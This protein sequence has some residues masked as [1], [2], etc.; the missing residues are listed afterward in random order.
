M[1]W[2]LGRSRRHALLAMIASAA[3][4]DGCSITR[5]PR[6]E[7]AL[8][9]RRSALVE[10]LLQGRERLSRKVVARIAQEQDR[11]AAAGRPE[12]VFDFLILSGGGDYGAFGAG[13]LKGWGTVTDPAMTR[14]TFDV[15]SGVSTGALIAPLAFV[16]TEETYE[17]AFQVYQNPKP[18]WSAIRGL[19]TSLLTKASFAKSDWLR[20]EIERTIDDPVIRGIE[21]GHEN[22]RVLLIGTT[23]ADLG[24]LV[25]WDAAQIAHQMTVEGRPRK[26]LDDVILA[27]ASIPGVFPPV[28][29]DGDLYVDGGVTRNIA[30]TTDQQSPI[31]AL[32][33]WKREHPNRKFPKIRMWIIIN[34]QLATSM[35][36]VDPGWPAQIGRAL[37]ISIRS[38]TIS[39]LKAMAILA[40]LNRAREGADI[41]YRYLC[42]P[43]DWR[44]PVPGNF[45][46]ETMVSLANLGYTLGADPKS[47]K[48]E[49]PDP[50]SPE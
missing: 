10:E 21:R 8:T 3:I 4:L 7:A 17:R 16:G 41:E 30:Y 32:N 26:H 22:N 1:I 31:S 14:P 37:E 6:T 38:S 24:L 13:V 46:K 48:T 45:Q 47:W 20:K 19:L 39:S 50:E 35:K 11:A 18:E 36:H 15:V 40:Q 29:I 42:I 44:P 33:I 23:N 12:P 5:P 2:K 49:V 9:A 27:S 43:D 34:N 25:M 28:E